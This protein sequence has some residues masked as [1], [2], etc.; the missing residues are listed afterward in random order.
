M[1]PIYLSDR[2]HVALF[3]VRL[4]VRLNPERGN[5]HRVVSVQ[6]FAIHHRNGVHPVIGVLIRC[7]RREARV[8]Q[9]LLLG[10]L[11]PL[12][13]RHADDKVAGPIFQYAL[14]T[15]VWAIRHL[16]EVIACSLAGIADRCSVPLFAGDPGRTHIEMFAIPGILKRLDLGIEQFYDGFLWISILGQQ[17][18]V[19]YVGESLS[20]TATVTTCTFIQGN[21]T[22]EEERCVHQSPTRALAVTVA[23]ESVQE[24]CIAP[25]VLHDLSHSAP[26]VHARWTRAGAHEYFISRKT[27]G[28]MGVSSVAP[29][30]SARAKAHILRIQ[31]L[32]LNPLPP[33]PCPASSLRATPLAPDSSALPPPGH[34]LFPCQTHGV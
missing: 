26:R 5:R 15:R 30:P 20:R 31:K 18:V 7:H 28:T 2:S 21:S 4:V 23:V 1:N 34:H 19:E 32:P 16:L 22:Q 14:E 17:A 33:P 11:E 12:V 6:H 13:V 3:G 8:F 9:L 24:A 27:V 25:T 29:P 10:S